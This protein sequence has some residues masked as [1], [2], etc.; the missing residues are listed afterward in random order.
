MS[1][2][3]FETIPHPDRAVYISWKSEEKRFTH[4]LYVG[5]NYGESAQFASYTKR[6]LVLWLNEA[7]QE[8]ID[9]ALRW[10]AE[11]KPEARVIVADRGL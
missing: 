4:F 10:V 7:T 1:K 5:T 3:P 6:N 8:A 11:N 9:G 2:N